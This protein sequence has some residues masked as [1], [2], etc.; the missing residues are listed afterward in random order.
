MIARRF[1]WREREIGPRSGGAA[2]RVASSTSPATVSITAA[3]SLKRTEPAEH[4]GELDAHGGGLVGQQ[5]PEA[6]RPRGRGRQ[7]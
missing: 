1:S 3:A 7:T 4:T 6:R 2:R 5:E